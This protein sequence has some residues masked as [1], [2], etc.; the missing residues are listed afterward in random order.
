[1]CDVEFPDAC[2][3]ISVTSVQINFM[4]IIHY[5]YLPFD[6]HQVCTVTVAST[7]HPLDRPNTEVVLTEINKIWYFYFPKL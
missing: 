5:M 3:S 4:L 7:V 2:I 1:M 6:H